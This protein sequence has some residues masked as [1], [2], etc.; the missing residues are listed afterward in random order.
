[1]DVDARKGERACTIQ[2]DEAAVETMSRHGEDEYPRK[3][4]VRFTWKKSR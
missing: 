3:K 1:V 2:A 4:I